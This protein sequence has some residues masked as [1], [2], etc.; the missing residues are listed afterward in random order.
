MRL[1]YKPL[2]EVAPRGLLLYSRGFLSRA[3]PVERLTTTRVGKI[4]DVGILLGSR[5]EEERKNCAV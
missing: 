2:L 3:G 4:S 1:E 5:I